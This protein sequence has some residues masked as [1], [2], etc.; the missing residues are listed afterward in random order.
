MSVFNRREFLHRSAILSAAAAGAETA[1]NSARAAEAAAAARKGSVN[2]RLRV[3]VVGVRSR[4]MSHVAGFLGKNNC[5]IVAI[6]DVDEAV[7]GKAMTRV[8]SVQKQTPLYVKDFRK[9]LDD[10]SIDIISVATPNHWHALMAVWAMRAGKD[11]YC[12]KPLTH[13]V[14][15]GR[16]IVEAAKKYGRI[17]QTGT[18]SR[19]NP[20]MRE[21]IDYLLSGKAGTVE[22]AYGTCYKLRESI[23]KVDGPQ[24]PPATMDYDLWCGPARVIPPHRKT[25][26]GT[27]HYDWHWIWEYGNGD[28][29]N[30]GVHEADKARWGLGQAGFPS[31]LVSVGGRLGYIDDGETPNTQLALFTYPDGRHLMFEVR[32]LKTEPY[33][34]SKVGNIWFGTEGYVVCPS[35][36]GGF[37]YDRD[38]KKVAEFKGGGDQYHFDNFVNAV[39]SRKPESLNCPAEE[40]HQSSALC[41]LANISYRLGNE[42]PL[43]K[44]DAAFAGYKPAIEAL[45]RMREHLMSNKVDV[46]RELGRIGTVLTLD[47]KTEKITDAGTA[48]LAKA[49]AMLFREYRKG[50]DITEAV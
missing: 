17:C 46:S 26:N 34:S 15:E 20:G 1:A 3:A 11:V 40:G 19:S 37:A 49:N 31:T 14:H 35:Y 4:G 12:E 33:M 38:G 45:A 28:F 41:H 24:A 25:K 8:E 29:G 47:P 27:V 2:D 36:A 16:L 21:A 22:L 10:K 7:I 6:C 42:A 18:Q 43:S 13:N 48:D 23:G 32:G 9:L 44:A 30:Q 50:F 5:E 39:R